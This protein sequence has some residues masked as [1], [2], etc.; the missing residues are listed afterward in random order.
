M[1]GRARDCRGKVSSQPSA[2]ALPRPST[3]CLR[4]A[5]I[6]VFESFLLVLLLILK[7][8][9]G[10]FL[11][12]LTQSNLRILNEGRRIEHHLVSCLQ[13]RLDDNERVVAAA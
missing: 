9:N 8:L 4:T 13:T 5:L 1:V 12:S 11:H 3:H 7:K 2:L 10:L 6:D